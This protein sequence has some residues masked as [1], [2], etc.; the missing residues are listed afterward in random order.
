MVCIFMLDCDVLK[1]SCMLPCARNLI[2]P[3]RLPKR[4]RFG[5]LFELGSK[6]SGFF[7]S[8]MCMSGGLGFETC[9]RVLLSSILHE[10]S[11]NNA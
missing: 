11:R 8:S 10:M 6:V 3:L 7:S 9:D 4:E 5:S 1:C 2:L